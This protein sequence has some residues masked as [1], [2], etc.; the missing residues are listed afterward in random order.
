VPASRT[1]TRTSEAP[2]S[3]S[4]V[5]VRA[6]G[7]IPDGVVDDVSEENREKPGVAGD[8]RVTAVVERDV[9]VLREGDRCELADGRLEHGPEL[10]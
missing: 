9:H 8:A 1:V 4:T 10:H 6:R 2:T 3:R 7:A 5:D